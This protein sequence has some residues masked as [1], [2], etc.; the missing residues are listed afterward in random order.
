MDIHRA[1]A[2]LLSPVTIAAISSLGVYAMYPDPLGLTVA[3]ILIVICPVANVVKKSISGE[4]DILVPDRYARGPFFVQA[5]A[6]YSIA[7]IV[8]M[9]LGS[10]PLAV[11]SLSYLAVTL[12]IALIN[13]YATKVSVHMA[14]LAGPAAFLIILGNYTLGALLMVLVPVLAWSRWRS[15][16]HTPG[17]IL[18][19]VVVSMLITTITCFVALSLK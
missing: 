11:L 6:C 13:H 14:G 5:I 16:S 7:T 3:L 4:M 9:A 1:I 10:C 15:G 19:G 8:L 18:L 12:A 17:Q 2:L